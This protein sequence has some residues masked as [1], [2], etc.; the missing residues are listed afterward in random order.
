M[1]SFK[2]QKKVTSLIFD[3]MPQII[4]QSLIAFN[5]IY[6]YS[7]IALTNN[8]LYTSIIAAI[9]NLIFQTIQLILI[10]NGVNE[11]F[12]SYALISVISRTGWVPF[13]QSNDNIILNNNNGILNY[14]IEYNIPLITKIFD[15]KANF[16]HDISNITI[17]YL[18]TALNGNNTNIKIIVFGNSLRLLNIQNLILLIETCCTNNIQLSE[19]LNFNSSFDIS[20]NNNEDIRII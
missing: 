4:V 1:Q 13:V 12:E 10:S 20:A 5:I 7:K 15:V 19:L 14:N 17:K 16:E 6:D 11:T 3:T 8:Q 18:I 9:F 2:T